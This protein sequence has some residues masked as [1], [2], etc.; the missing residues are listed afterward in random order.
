M[1]YKPMA[2]LL[3]AVAVA[4][5]LP[6]GDERP[7]GGFEV[8]V[9]HVTPSDGCAARCDAPTPTPDQPFE[10][11]VLL[12]EEV[13]SVGPESTTPTPTP[14]PTAS[15][16]HEQPVATLRPNVHWNYDT[17]PAENVVPIPAE[18]G[19]QMY[20]GIN[21]PQESGEFAFL[22][23][24]FNRPSVNLDHTD[25]V[26]DVEYVPQ[27]GMTVHFSSNEA[28]D[29][30]VDTWSERDE[31]VL[32]TYT[33][34]CGAFD[35]QERCFF[36][37]SAITWD[38]QAHTIIAQGTPT[39]PDQIV[40]KGEAEW[41][42]WEPSGEA[43]TPP[44]A[45]PAAQ[46]SGVSRPAAGTNATAPGNAGCVAPVDAVHGLPTACFGRTFDRDL[47]ATLGREDLS[48]EYQDFLELVADAPRNVSR[49]IS[50][51]RGYIT[52]RCGWICKVVN[53]VVIEPVK[54]VFE[55]VQEALTVSGS[56]DEEFSFQVPDPS[57]TGP[58]NELLGDLVFVDSP[59]G[60]AIQ[61]FSIAGEAGPVSGDVTIFCVGCGVSGTARIAG[62]ASF[63][64]LEGLTEGFIELTSDL[65]FAVKLG[66]DAQAALSQDFEI[67]LFSV[68]LPGL[69][70]GI[71]TIGPRIDVGARVGLEAAAA[72][73]LLAGADLS[74]HGAG[75]VIDFVNSANTNAH[76]FTPVLTPVFEAQ[77]Q[78]SASATLALPV[79]LRFGIQIATFDVSAGIVD[80]PSIRGTAQVA[81][82]VGLGEDGQLEGGFLETDGC[83]GISAQLSFRNTL[84]AEITG[85]DNIDLLDT[86]DIVLAQGCIEI[87]GLIEGGEEAVSS[88]PL[89]L[90]SVSMPIVETRAT[91]AL[92]T[93][94]VEGPAIMTSVSELPTE[95]VETEVP[96]MEN[97]TDDLVA[98][99]VS[100]AP[101][102]LPVQGHNFTY[103]A[104]TPISI[105]YQDI[106]GSEYA[107]LIS[108]PSTRIS[109]CSNGNVYA[110][111]AAGSTSSSCSD[112]WE[113][114]AGA[115]VADGASRPMHY[116]NNTMSVLGVSRLR[117]E[118]EASVPGSGVVVAW[119]PSGEDSVYVAVDPKDQVLYPV[120]CEYEGGDDGP[121]VFLVKDLAV[122]TAVLES[123]EVRHSVTGGTVT[124]CSPLRLEKG[125]STVLGAAT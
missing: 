95:P 51:R 15:F 5:A 103:D 22:T 28:W 73:T 37:V 6:T 110:F 1:L 10:P 20:Y 120:V 124:R 57:G 94:V 64:P 58:V 115:L 104:S 16:V 12:V 77:G 34:G 117:V 61:L 43:A 59:F 25:H 107:H 81:A 82:G 4:H 102:V 56:L 36:Q 18:K 116:Y 39:H 60:D 80:E 114:K 54:T 92:T 125:S 38:D 70:F 90:P 41:G 106:T 49:A 71:I 44:T 40:S 13:E 93:P 84:F 62:K 119:A 98:P 8:V 33:E 32:I 79:G 24:Y 65:S 68:G 78:I 121:R 14:T 123:E 69:S 31:L 63:V 87:P 66:I 108:G 111:N 19:S 3:A 30:A 7:Q 42:W 112:T 21:S 29:Y 35:D 96:A 11:G 76:G 47:D 26:T 91:P 27:Q 72:G 85:L 86:G 97:P 17:T 99:P 52:R 88:T 89:A 83:A 53:K 101:E 100:T 67:D 75:A 23:Y 118:A 74:F 113:Y 2:A 48:H 46:T 109:S 45:S 122:G 55:T 105:S 50:R 9:V